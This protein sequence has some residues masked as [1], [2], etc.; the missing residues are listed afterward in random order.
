MFK[1]RNTFFEE[2]ERQSSNLE[3]QKKHKEL[4]E[5]YVEII[6]NESE[7]DRITHLM[8]ETGRKAFIKLHHPLDDPKWS[9]LGLYNSLK[10]TLKSN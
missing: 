1:E 5:D 8:R 10:K 4:F 9:N 6:E 7:K 2:L 3:F